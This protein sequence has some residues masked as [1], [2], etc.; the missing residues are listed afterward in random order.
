M[1]LFNLRDSLAKFARLF[2][3][4][5]NFINNAIGCYSGKHAGLDQVGR[6]YD[7][8]SSTCSVWHSEL[9]QGDRHVLWNYK[10]IKLSS[11]YTYP[12]RGL[13]FFFIHWLDQKDKRQRDMDEAVSN[14][15]LR[16]IMSF[17]EYLYPQPISGGMPT[18]RNPYDY[19]EGFERKDD[20]IQHLESEPEYKIVWEMR[21]TSLQ[22]KETYDNDKRRV[23]KAI[24]EGFRKD[25]QDAAI[26]LP[27][28]D[29][30]SSQP[31]EYFHTSTFAETLF[32]WAERGSEYEPFKIRS[33]TDERVTRYQIGDTIMAETLDQSKADSIGKLLKRVGPKYF[34]D[35]KSIQGNL[36]ESLRLK[37][38]FNDGIN[39]ILSDAEHVE[40]RGECD[41]CKEIIRR[42]FQTKP[43]V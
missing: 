23:F 30:K 18:I 35:A 40:L 3:V 21:N 26:M 14:H 2:K 6:G 1:V 8:N 28:W 37:S 39:R 41:T 38:A 9:W 42:F 43:H 7:P 27:E 29:G 11:G 4:G 19:I 15:K 34:E 10:R 13:G 5:T 22:H 25:I 36:R 16:L 17:K 24:E 12:R 20:F 33:F 31:K 32:K